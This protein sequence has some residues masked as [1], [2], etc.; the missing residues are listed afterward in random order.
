MSADEYLRT[1]AAEQANL[2]AA[3]GVPIEA[4]ERLEAVLVFYL[5]EEW[6]VD[7]RL[8][9]IVETVA[10]NLGTYVA[11]K[12][13]EEALRSERTILRRL[14]DTNPVGVMVVNSGGVITRTNSRADNI[15]GVPESGL[16]SCDYTEPGAQLLNSSGKPVPE[17]EHPI[18]QVF[19]TGDEI[20]DEQFR[21]ERRDGSKLWISINAA[22][23][24]DTDGEIERVVI[25]FEDVT[26]RTERER[27]LSAFRRAVEHAGQAIYIMDSEGKINYAN[28]RFEEL[29][30]YDSEAI[31]GTTPELLLADGND[32][33][34]ALETVQSGDIWTGEVTNQRKSGEE[35]VVN[36][37]ITPITDSQGDIGRLVGIDTDISERKERE[38]S[39]R[40]HRDALDR[41]KQLL[42]TLAGVH[43]TMLEASSFEELQ[44]S[45][46]DYLGN[47]G[48]YSGAWC[49]RVHSD[50]TVSITAT[51]NVDAAVIEDAIVKS[52][53]P[54]FNLIQRAIETGKIQ[55]ARRVPGNEPDDVAL[56]LPEHDDTAVAVIP[57]SYGE[58]IYSVLCLYSSRS[59]AF[60]GTERSL[61][62][63]LGN[64]IGAD[65]YAIT[66]EELLQTNDRVE[67]EFE[68][69]TSDILAT[70][71]EEHDCYIEMNRVIPAG[72]GFIHYLVINGASL[73]A[74]KQRL[75]AAAGITDVSLLE[76]SDRPQL[77]CHLSNDSLT[78]ALGEHGVKVSAGSFRDGTGRVVA[79]VTAQTDVRRLLEQVR[80][81]VPDTDLIARRTINPHD[82][83]T[84][85]GGSFRSID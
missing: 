61:L 10:A 83:R 82:D 77:R 46:C 4:E 73:D 21:V 19:E 51:N 50:D 67:L 20:Y 74:V 27:E 24:F 37:T 18:S 11:R 39:V 41:A 71:S 85:T 56:P 66:T 42:G 26:E 25:A 45:V 70:I 44:K 6:P 16:V 29:S 81:V 72:D 3:Y 35:I 52:Q 22:P 63:D 31:I 48:I 12:R 9:R 33:D 76:N 14:F 75:S 43:G 84:M 1:D 49:G 34:D 54:S 15:F 47:S 13:A 58:A 40:H 55:T 38:R 60:E 79:E 57:I 64:R 28:E 2:K 65:A 53:S 8:S 32:I 36:R 17:E 7:Y 30:G 5:T 80:T 68:T 78:V 69:G 62:S 59:T 23:L